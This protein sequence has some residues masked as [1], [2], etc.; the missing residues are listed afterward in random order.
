MDALKESLAR[1]PPP[2]KK[3]P[4]KIDRPVASVKAERIE[5]KA[6]AGRK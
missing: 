4:A 6:Q 1:R 3:P 2:G 5:K